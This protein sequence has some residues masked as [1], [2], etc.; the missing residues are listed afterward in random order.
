M[1]GLYYLAA[2]A[3]FMCILQV[4]TRWF[5]ADFPPVNDAAQLGAYLIAILAYLQWATE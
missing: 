2:F 1:A 4:A 3:N 5:V